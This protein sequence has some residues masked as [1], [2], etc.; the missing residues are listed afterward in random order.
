[1]YPPYQSFRTDYPVIIQTVFW[2]KIN[3]KQTPLFQRCHHGIRN[4]L[5]PQQFFAKGIIVNSDADYTFLLHD[6]RPKVPCHTFAQ[7]EWRNP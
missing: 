1:M 4:R 3:N 7:Q 6:P 2:L 5:F